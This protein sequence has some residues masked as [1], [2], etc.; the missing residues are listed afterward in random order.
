MNGYFLA[1]APSLKQTNKNDKRIEQTTKAQQTVMALAGR[2]AS[3]L[4][5]WGRWVSMWGWWGCMSAR[6]ANRKVKLVSRRAM[7]ECQM[8]TWVSTWVSS[9]RVYQ[10]EVGLY[11]GEVGESATWSA[12]KDCTGSGCSCSI[13]NNTNQREIDRNDK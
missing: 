10:G 8:V 11:F 2:W 7:W 4:S 1:F 12:M 13:T 5:R 6:S 3:R 9:W